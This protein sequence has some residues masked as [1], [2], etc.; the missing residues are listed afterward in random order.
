M[1]T[2]VQRTAVYNKEMMRSNGVQAVRD[3]DERNLLRWVSH[4]AGIN[5][6][7]CGIS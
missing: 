5:V 1:H 2:Y 6:C 4:D 7:G 3:W